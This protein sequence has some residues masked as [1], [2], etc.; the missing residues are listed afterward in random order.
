M[1]AV[2]FDRLARSLIAPSRRGFGRALAGLGLA[3]GVSALL[4][5]TDGEAKKRKRKKKKCRGETKKC[6][7]RCIPK[8][9]C[10]T[11]GDCDHDHSFHCIDGVCAC[12]A[13]GWTSCGDKCIQEG[14]CCDAADCQSEGLDLCVDNRCQCSG[15]FCD[16]AGCCAAGEVCNN[17]ERRCEPGSCPSV[18]ACD[19]TEDFYTCG[20]SGFCTCTTSVNGGPW[21]VDWETRDCT[22]NCTSDAHCGAGR[23]CVSRTTSAPCA[24]CSNLA[25]GFCVSFGNCRDD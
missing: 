3:G 16:S 14:G 2:R 15:F 7:K 23:V 9:N 5:G 24:S 12:L 6:G 18:Q 1:D 11:S 25:N 10:C 4:R 17:S 21:C 13:D 22:A 19:L 20:N 8:A